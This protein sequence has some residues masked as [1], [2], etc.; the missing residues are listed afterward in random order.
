MRRAVEYTLEQFLADKARGPDGRYLTTPL[1]VLRHFLDGGGKRLRPLYCCLGW[2]AVS[3]QSLPEQV[4][5]AAGGLE[6]FHTY[7]LLHD[8]VIDRSDT[9]HDR[10]TAHRV[11][12]SISPTRRTDW[13]GQ[14]A[15]ILLGDLCEAWSAELLGGSEP[16]RETVRQIVD[17]MRGEL[18]LGQYLDLCATGEKPSTV[19]HALTVIGYKATK[20]TIERPLQIGAALAVADQAVLDACAAY[21]R[22]LGEAFQLFDDLQDVVADSANPTVAGNDLREGKYTVVLALAFQRATHSQAGR[23]RRLVGSETLDHDGLA[24]AQALIAATGTPDVARSMIAERR[25][26]ALAI[27]DGAPFRGQAVQALRELTDLALPGVAGWPVRALDDL[28]LPRRP[29]HMPA[30]GQQ[31]HPTEDSHA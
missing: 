1:N 28:P 23:L 5:R 9:R 16:G 26:R 25:A 15:A 22:P 31:S 24:E 27:L 14:S 30:A 6:L 11:F 3:G 13:F 19:E 4:L 8:D 20:Y 29:A 2:H 21:A 7:A 18:A 12:S 10:P 17:R